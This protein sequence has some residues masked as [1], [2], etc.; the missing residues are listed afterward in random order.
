MDIGHAY[1]RSP[2][3]RLNSAIKPPIMRK[4]KAVIMCMIPICFASV[5]RSTRA[6]AEPFTCG[7][8]GQG[9]AAISFG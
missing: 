5:V 4:P 6:R 8:T 9:P 3:V 7:L 1:A 2:A